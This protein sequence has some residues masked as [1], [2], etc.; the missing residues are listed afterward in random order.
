MPAR[1]GREP[2]L[3]RLINHRTTTM[4]TQER[5]HSSST[6]AGSHSG[7]S[8]STS[9]SNS[10]TIAGDIPA[11]TPQS[12]SISSTRPGC[13]SATR[14]A[15]CA[16]TAGSANP[17][18]APGQRRTQCVHACPFPIPDS[19]PTNQPRHHAKPPSSQPRTATTH[20][21][22]RCSDGRPSGARGSAPPVRS[23]RPRAPQ[24]LRGLPPRTMV[25][26]STRVRAATCACRAT[27]RGCAP[28]VRSAAVA[29]PHAIQATA[30]AR[31]PRR[32]ARRDAASGLAHRRCRPR[33]SPG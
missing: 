13:A 24:A 11:G 17:L 10:A 16:P 26:N 18:G 30:A 32:P 28:A 20:D 3:A 2:R 6:P 22:P 15:A 1:Q 8:T 23:R 14:N 5:A 31:R 4:E 9:V 7:V 27:P 33:R 25:K 29:R 21:T 19:V 12:A